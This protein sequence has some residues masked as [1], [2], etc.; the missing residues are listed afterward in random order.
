MLKEVPLPVRAGRRN[1]PIVGGVN[2]GAPLP[3][4]AGAAAVAE[5]AAVAL[6]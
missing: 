6:D 1:A 4:V 3:P 5:G 2:V